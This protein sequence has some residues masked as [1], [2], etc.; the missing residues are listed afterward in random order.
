M[1]QI[2]AQTS[3]ANPVVAILRKCSFTDVRGVINKER[4]RKRKN[5]VAVKL[6]REISDIWTACVVDT[7]AISSRDRSVP[8]FPRPTDSKTAGEQM[9]SLTTSCENHR[10]SWPTSDVYVTRVNR[11]TIDHVRCSIR[12][13]AI[14]LFGDARPPSSRL[15]ARVAGFLSFADDQQMLIKDSRLVRHGCTQHPLHVG[16]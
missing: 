3:D 13:I 9:G 1:S 6:S 16:N 8:V 12:C 15:I 11:G 14:R 2:D 5:R 10:S 4:D 7:V